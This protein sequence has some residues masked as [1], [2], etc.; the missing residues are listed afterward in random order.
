MVYYD[1]Q[2]HSDEFTLLGQDGF[3]E[4][5]FNLNLIYYMIL[6]PKHVKF[7]QFLPFALSVAMC[8]ENLET[9]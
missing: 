2:A 5:K 3:V 1:S 7:L 6:S 8:G 4:L 9:P